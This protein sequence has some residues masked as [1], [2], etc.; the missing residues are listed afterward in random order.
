VLEPILPG[1]PD[2]VK[3]FYEKLTKAL[4]ARAKHFPG[5][6]WRAPPVCSRCGGTGLITDPELLQKYGGYFDD[7]PEA[8][9]CGSS[10]NT[11]TDE[12]YPEDNDPNWP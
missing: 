7:T 10:P 2:A 3:R 9:G 4:Y 12:G 1:G 8:C 5:R 11:S 6:D